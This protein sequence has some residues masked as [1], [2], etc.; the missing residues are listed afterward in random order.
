MKKLFAIIACL[1]C[2]FVLFA[3]NSGNDGNKENEKEKEQEQNPT[4]ETEE[5]KALADS[6]KGFCDGKK[7]YLTTLGQADVDTVEYFLTDLGFKDGTE[8]TRKD[9]LKAADVEADAIVLIVTGTSGKGLG[10]A[11]TD[12]TGEKT[13]A[14]GFASATGFKKIVFHVGGIDRRGET[15]DPILSIICPKCDL[16]LVVSGANTDN[17]FSNIATSNN[18]ELNLYSKKSKVSAAVKTLF[19]K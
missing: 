2:A 14:Q 16:M 12:F 15:T 18:I 6:W 3:C 5:D 9:D 10:A 4:V 1:V 19:N 17:F 13:R 8:Y 7:V 11:G